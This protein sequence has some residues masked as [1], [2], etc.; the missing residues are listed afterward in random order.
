MS[1]EM[2][3]MD[4][5]QGAI[6]VQ[7]QVNQIQYLMK[8]VLKE[9]E[10]YGTV[11][12]CGNKPTLLQPGAEKIAYMFHLIPSYEVT[13]RDLGHGHREYEVTCTLTHRDTGE[14]VGGGMGLCSTL[15]SKYRYRNKWVNGKKVREENPDIA[16]VLNTVLKIAKKRAFVDAV[17]STTAASDIFTQD[18]EDMGFTN[19]SEP[20]KPAESDEI[21]KLNKQLWHEVG[22]LKKQAISLDVQ[23]SAITSWM[24][25]HIKAEDGSAKAHNTYKTADILK[26][27]DY[28]QTLI[29]DAET[30]NVEE[31]EVVDAEIVEDGLYDED[32]SF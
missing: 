18:I 3:V 2:V 11:P 25:A 26:V 5:K 29:R 24:E 27:R 7:Q 12:G 23:E 4:D 1:N 28:L 14:I 6:E 19:A 21:V 10:H 32:V 20:S 17:K 16:D 22:E 31:V 8:K 9:G 13:R 30:T 15:E